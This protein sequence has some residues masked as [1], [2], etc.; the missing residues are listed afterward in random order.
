MAEVKPTF[1]KAAFLKQRPVGTFKPVR[2]RDAAE[3][4][5]NAA[6]GPIHIAETY[7]IHDDVD[8]SKAPPAP[9]PIPAAPKGMGGI[10]GDAVKKAAK[11][12]PVAL[13]DPADG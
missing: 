2:P 9:T 7:A 1:S 3:A 12:V 13:F 5:H 11:H 4:I 10:I 6:R 8:Y